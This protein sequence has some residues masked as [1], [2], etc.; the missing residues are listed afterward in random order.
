MRR[1]R[2]IRSA[3]RSGTKKKSIKPILIRVAFVLVLVAVTTSAALLLGSYLDE[4]ANFAE[5]LLETHEKSEPSNE[6][7]E[8]FPGGVLSDSDVTEKNVCAAHIEVVGVSE[9][10]VTE[11]IRALGDMYSAVSI[12]VV[13]PTGSLVY[14]SDALM[15]YVRLDGDLVVR[16]SAGEVEG[17]EVEGDALPAIKTALA[18]ADELGMRKSAVFS[19]SSNVL[20]NSPISNNER[21][22][23]GI[24]LGEM[25]DMGFDEVILTSLVTEDAEITTE[26]LKKIV[27]YLS[28]L[29]DYSGEIDIGVVLPSSV[30][31]VP[32]SA[33]FIKTL[34][35]YAD[36]LAISVNTDAEDPAAAYSSV[37]DNCHSLKGNFSVYNIRGMIETDDVE[38][39]QAV[40]AALCDLSVKSV[41][42][43]TYVS[44]PVYVVE[45]PD[46]TPDESVDTGKV[47]DNAVS[48]EDY[49]SNDENT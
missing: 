46:D 48:K 49:L 40:Y 17:S 24:I 33:S 11:S 31:L 38:V 25:Y 20:E 8:M 43:S 1:R 13:S 28:S 2:L 19:A 23:D 18:V 27:S 14:L 37:Y 26:L 32:Q 7:T 6:K 16:P 10:S 5:S 47:N 34:S 3:Y 29:R 9:E 35:E 15:N 12:N 4:R 22:T 44:D 41:Q 36:F 30:Y 42:F 39:A 21:I 45:I